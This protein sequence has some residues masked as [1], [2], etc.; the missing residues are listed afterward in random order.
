MKASIRVMSSQSGKQFVKACLVKMGSPNREIRLFDKWFDNALG[1]PCGK[2]GV[3][4][5]KYL[6]D[7]LVKYRS[8][9]VTEIKDMEEAM[10]WYQG[11]AKTF[12]FIDADEC[13]PSNNRSVKGIYKCEY[14]SMTYYF[15]IGKEEA[16]ISQDMRENGCW[17][18]YTYAL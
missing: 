7:R 5:A 1:I 3:E 17:Y 6:Y 11:I 2:E 12:A 15:G 14:R 18:V 4:Y 9:K 8:I 16:N 13:I 10:P